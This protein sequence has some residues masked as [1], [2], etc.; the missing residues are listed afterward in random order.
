M[1]LIVFI[2]S[3]LVKGKD[4]FWHPYFEATNPSD[5]LSFWDMKE[6]REL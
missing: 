1:T 3:E 5:L 2:M 6:L 4:S